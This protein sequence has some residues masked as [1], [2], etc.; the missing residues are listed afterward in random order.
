VNGTDQ[1]LKT[2]AG[3]AMAARRFGRGLWKAADIRLELGANEI[4]RRPLVTEVPNMCCGFHT[5]GDISSRFLTNAGRTSA[6][7]SPCNGKPTTQHLD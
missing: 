3:A 2:L 6:H 1:Q 4:R 7:Y 5:K